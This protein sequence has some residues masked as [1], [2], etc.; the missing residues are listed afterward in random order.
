MLLGA[1]A[2]GG[3]A[4]SRRRRGITRWR[5]RITGRTWASRSPSSCRKWAPLVKVSNCRSFGADVVLHG[6]TYDEAKH[7]AWRAR[8]A[9]AANVYV[10]GF[11]DPD[12]IAGQ[13][14]MGL[15][16][17]EDVPDVDAVIVPVGGGGLI[18]GVG[19]GDQGA[20]A[21]GAGDRRRAGQRAD[22]PRVARS[23]ARS[24]TS[25]RKPTLADGL[26]VAE[27]GQALLRD[28]PAGDRR[29]GAWWTRRRSRSR[30]CGCWSWRRRSSK[31]PAPCRWRRR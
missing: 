7:Q 19:A 8:G 22:A 13:G 3:A 25:T 12:I 4:S 6:E 20:A 18:A 29:P 23:R 24:C 11:D 26:A 1:G 14:T 21:G 31:A 15:E 30:S 27:V 5:W 2:S 17:L 28:R 16:I 9:E 10:P